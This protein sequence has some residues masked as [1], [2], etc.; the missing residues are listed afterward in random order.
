M[1]ALDYAIVLGYVAV[2]LG[3][4]LAWARGQRRRE[5]YLV[6]SRSM[7][8]MVVGLSVMATAFSAMNYTA[9][10][11]EVFRHGLYIAL[12]VPM[13][14]MIS[15]VITRVVMPFYHDMRLCSAYEYLERRFDLSVRR[16]ASGLFVLWRLVWM[17]VT[18]YAAC[19]VLHLLTKVDL[20]LLIVVA[21]A[22]ATVY[23]A[24][25]GMRAVMWTDV[26]QFGV[27]L[28]GVVVGV[29]VAAAR[30]P[31]GLLGMMRTAADAGCMR[32]FY[33]FDP[34][35][36][37][38]D[39]TV[40]ITLWSAW[41]GT[42]VIFLGRYSADQ[43]VVQRY[44]AARTLRDAQR[45][46][47]LN[48]AAAIVTLVCLAFMG[49]AIRAHAAAAGGDA[50]GPP[51][52]HF[53]RFVCSLPSG[54]CGLIVAGLFAAAMS[55]VDSGI[56]SCSAAFIVD[57]WGRSRPGRESLGLCRTLTVVWGASAAAAA[58][59]IARLDRSLF[60]M[61]AKIVNGLGSPLLAVVLLAALSRRATSRG[62]FVG[63][64]L[65]AGFSAWLSFG[66]G[67]LALH[68]Y[69]VANLVVTMGLCYGLS[70]V[71]GPRPRPEQL[72]WTWWA[73]R[74]RTCSTV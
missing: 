3:M 31:E 17:G 57:F 23:T 48:Y 49:F 28:A 34:Q 19:K 12:S 55:S 46:F 35:V 2:C 18:L 7:P 72:A 8:W 56:H 1:S 45:G 5:E 53:A 33:P 62:V 27:L 43:V 66:Y 39:P 68:Y 71:L 32:P 54:V 37:S 63:G 13:F 29:A 42:F 61:A 26:V 64:L 41:L 69:P 11:G 22:A 50:A 25:G 40:R 58:C 44:F 16:L 52:V 65:G 67:P 15:P 74:H 4:G 10:S 51:V 30:S 59:A 70:F 24:A 38:W 73:R 47:R 6:A 21:G 36:L 14:A 20:D 60:V 9:F